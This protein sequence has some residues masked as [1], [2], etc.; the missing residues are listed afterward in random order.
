MKELSYTR[1]CLFTCSPIIQEVTRLKSELESLLKALNIFVDTPCCI[2]TQEESKRLIHGTAKEKYQFFLKATG[3]QSVYDDLQRAERDMEEATARKDDV[4]P[5]VMQ[6]KADYEAARARVEEFRQLDG[7]EDKIRH[8]TAL[9]LWDD[10]RSEQAVLDGLKKQASDFE[11]AVE[12]A[13]S[14]LDADSGE[15]TDSQK[16][17]EANLELERIQTE[18][19]ERAAAADAKQAE[20]VQLQR[21][22]DKMKSSMREHVR[23]ISE[24]ETRIRSNEQ[25]VCTSVFNY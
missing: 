25:E 17:A 7:I 12:L 14:E 18:V 9:L 13:Q 11:E 2:L 3:L 22:H 24:H 8:Q 10:V 19:D 4:M 6:R 16:I 15:D 20:G 21:A 1:L 23:G 5:L